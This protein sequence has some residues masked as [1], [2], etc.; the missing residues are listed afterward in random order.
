MNRVTHDIEINAATGN[1]VTIE[2]LEKLRQDVTENL[3]SRVRPDGTGAD[4]DPV[5]GLVGDVYDIQNE[6][7]TRI[8]EAFEAHQQLQRTIQRSERPSIETLAG[9]KR[10]TV[11]HASGDDTAFI[12]KV[13]VQ[14]ASNRQTVD[15]TFVITR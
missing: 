2:G 11:N 6:I 5:V 13:E 12:I 1:F 9:L 15:T 10:L 3:T 7:R 4:L 14:S 8:N